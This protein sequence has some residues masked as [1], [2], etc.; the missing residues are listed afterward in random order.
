MADVIA[1]MDDVVVMFLIAMRLMLL[2]LIVFCLFDKCYYLVAG[3]VATVLLF[4][5]DVFAWRLMELPTMGVDGRWISHWVNT[6]VLILMFCAG[7]HPICEADGTCLY[8][9]LRMGH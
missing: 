2:P 7:P 8:F 1:K 5:A 9:Y 4:L 6:L 3:V